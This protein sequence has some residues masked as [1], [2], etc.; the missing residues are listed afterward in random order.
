MA[1]QNMP[2]TRYRLS[3]PAADESTLAWID[4]QLNLSYSIRMLIREDIQKNGCTDVS[5][6]AV[7]QGAKRGRPTNA[8]LERRSEGVGAAVGAS[9]PQDN[10]E[11]AAAARG[12][13]APSEGA[14]I[15]AMLESMMNG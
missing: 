15:N 10:P 4:A 6:R 11:H 3:V 14:D 8:E 1:K 2:S 12:S 5:C 9:Q 13:A 7:E